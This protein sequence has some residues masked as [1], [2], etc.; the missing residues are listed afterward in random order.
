M[1][2]G[3]GFRVTPNTEQSQHP[4]PELVVTLLLEGSLRNLDKDSFAKSLDNQV[5]GFRV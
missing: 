3:L 1:S 5:L 4:T 2:T